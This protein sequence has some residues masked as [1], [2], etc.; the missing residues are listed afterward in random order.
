[1]GYSQ[2]DQRSVCIVVSAL[3]RIPTRGFRAETDT[4]DKGNDRK[5]GRTKLKPPNNLPNVLQRQIGAKPDEDT[6]G[7]PHSPI[8]H[9]TTSN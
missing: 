4:E 5:K 9:E 2:F 7:D 1:M 3:L 8:H 6:E